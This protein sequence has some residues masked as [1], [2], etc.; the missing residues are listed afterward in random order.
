M[1]NQPVVLTSIWLLDTCGS[2]L[3][4]YS[5]SQVQKLE[6]PIREV[7]QPEIVAAAENE[8]SDGELDC[9]L[10]FPTLL[11]KTQLEILC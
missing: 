8:H 11:T 6:D 7:H 2:H 4:K 9:S 10:L 1:C 5:H 3:P